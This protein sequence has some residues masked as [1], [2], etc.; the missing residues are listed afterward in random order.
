[1]SHRS[2]NRTKK[3]RGPL[4]S[5]RILFL[6]VLTPTTTDNDL[7]Y[8]IIQD[9]LE[10]IASPAITDPTLTTWVY[11]DG[12]NYDTADVNLG[13]YPSDGMP[14]I[15]QS[16]PGIYDTNGNPLTG[17][18]ITTSTY[19]TFDHD[20]QKMVVRATSQNELNGDDPQTVAEFV[21]NALMDCIPRG[22]TEY[23]L[24][25]SSHGSG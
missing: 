2:I 9:L 21:Y 8:F 15:T 25:F 18:K 1:M 24:I 14:V 6:L 10:L 13:Y 7:E 16:L 17:G 12:R 20:L 11:H 3:K 5:C 23:V 19:M 22:S 4:Q